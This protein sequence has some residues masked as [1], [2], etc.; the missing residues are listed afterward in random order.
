M[1][2]LGVCILG[3]PLGSDKVRGERLGKVYDIGG[4]QPSYVRATFP[5]VFRR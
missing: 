5:P 4:L 2:C 1:V 3:S